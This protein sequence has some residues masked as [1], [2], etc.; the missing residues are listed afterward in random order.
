ML[1]KVGKATTTQDIK[2]YLQ[3]KHDD[4]VL[5]SY[6]AHI[7]DN[8]VRDNDDNYLTYFTGNIDVLYNF[9]NTVDKLLQETIE[10]YF[11]EAGYVNNI[12]YV[13]LDN[14]KIETTSTVK[15]NILLKHNY[16]KELYNMLNNV[17]L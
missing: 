12:D 5:K 10:T 1:N 2:L 13:K 9:Q 14:N 7:C 8:N 17:L 15:H 4:I 11:I 3:H 6:I 16:D